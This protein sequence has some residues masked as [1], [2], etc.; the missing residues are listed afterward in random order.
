MSLMQWHS[1]GTVAPLSTHVSSLDVGVASKIEAGLSKTQGKRPAPW[2]LF[3]A[4]SAALPSAA[5]SLDVTLGAD[6]TV[7]TIER[8]SS[9]TDFDLET[10]KKTDALRPNFH[11]QWRLFGRQLA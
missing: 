3:D 5:L 4:L 10:L 9:L 1:K 6:I 11:N 8:I 7:K 2:E